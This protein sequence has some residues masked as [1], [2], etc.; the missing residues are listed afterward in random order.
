LSD[1]PNKRVKLDKPE[2]VEK[3]EE[4]PKKGL[5]EFM[6]VMK[7]VDESLPVASTSKLGETTG[8]NAAVPGE[9]G[10][11]ADGDVNGKG[12]GKGK[13]HAVENPQEL[14]QDVADEDDDAAWLSRRQNAA[15]ESHEDAEVPAIIEEVCIWFSRLSLFGACTV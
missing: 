5:K 4:R 7:G 13:L 11:V 9:K 14:V 6:N 1:K 10:W 8:V 2:K 15:L 12:K 3:V